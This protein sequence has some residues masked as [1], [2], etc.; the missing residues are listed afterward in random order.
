M[1]PAAGTGPATGTEVFVTGVHANAE[2][3]ADAAAAVDAYNRILALL[4][5]ISE[6]N[7]ALLKLRSP[8]RTGAGR[9]ARQVK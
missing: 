9:R 8:G 1:A 4:D 7:L 3:L 6:I 2:A 5:R